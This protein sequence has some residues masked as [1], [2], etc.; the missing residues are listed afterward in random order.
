[1]A[2]PWQH[3]PTV[4]AQLE[5]LRGRVDNQSARSDALRAMADA[6]GALAN[7]H[8][9]G[10]A[11]GDLRPQHIVHTPR[12]VALLNLA[13]AHNPSVKLRPEHDLPYPGPLVHCRTPGTAR[14]LLAGDT[15]TPTPTDDVYAL[16]AI[17]W[18]SLTDTWPTNYQAAGLKPEPDDSLA[19]QRAVAS[20]QWRHQI[21]LIEWRAVS[22]PLRAA[23]S[24]QSQDRPTARDLADQLGRLVAQ[25]ADE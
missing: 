5:Q 12:G 13:W 24:A 2:R 18:H 6:A 8:A 3:G 15:I 22:A 1:M 11:H 25:G 20:E 16:A 23:L 19:V 4:D 14:R 10:W 21:E 17:W 7:L 9:L